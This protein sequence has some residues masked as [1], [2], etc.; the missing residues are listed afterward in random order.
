MKIK[1]IAAYLRLREGVDRSLYRRS[2]FSDRHEI[3]AFL[4]WF[5]L[6][7]EKG[8]NEKAE[9]EKIFLEKYF[10]HGIYLGA[11]IEMLCKDSTLLF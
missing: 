7:N 4:R 3:R 8:K 10:L 5:Q 11:I 2:C 6:N 9:K 1:R